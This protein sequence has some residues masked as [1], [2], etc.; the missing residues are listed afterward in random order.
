MT[1]EKNN[2]DTKDDKEDDGYGNGFLFLC[3]RVMLN[4]VAM[5]LR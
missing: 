5:L 2:N 3:L 4:G 1:N